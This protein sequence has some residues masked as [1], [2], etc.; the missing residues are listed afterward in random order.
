[1]VTQQMV[2]FNDTI[3]ANIGYGKPGATREEIIEAAKRAFAHEFIELLPDG[4]DAVIGEQG[5]GLSGGQLQRIVI[6]RA[7]LK[8]PAILIFDE[9]T[10][11]VDADSEAKIHK[12]IEEIMHDRTT[13]I[14]AHRF[15]TIISADTIVVMDNG[16]IIAQGQHE[17]LIQTCPLYQSLYETQL[18]KA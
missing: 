1:M 13:L 8:N 10:S 9:A 7:V 5:T 11:Q 3:A 2:T 18:V 4:Y 12:A 17:E 14:I 15:S 6:A 16:R